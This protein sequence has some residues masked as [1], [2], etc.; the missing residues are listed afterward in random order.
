MN[1]IMQQNGEDEN[2]VRYLKWKI[3]VMVDISEFDRG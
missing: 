2:Q 3:H 1:A